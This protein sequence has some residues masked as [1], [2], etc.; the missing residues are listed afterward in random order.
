MWAWTLLRESKSV[1][2]LGFEWFLRS[3]EALWLDFSFN[4]LINSLA[5]LVGSEENF[6]AESI[7]SWAAFFSTPSKL[8]SGKL[9]CGFGWLGWIAYGSA[10]IW[11]L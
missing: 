3:K 11:T 8:T 5:K 1:N 9:F 7:S 2:S 10:N 6:C 4:N